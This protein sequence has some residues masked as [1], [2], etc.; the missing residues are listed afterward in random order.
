MGGKVSVNMA[1]LVS[2]ATQAVRQTTDRTHAHGSSPVSETR[3]YALTSGG[4]Y[5]NISIPD[6]VG[7]GLLPADRVGDMAPRYVPISVYFKDEGRTML[8]VPWTP[9]AGQDPA[10]TTFKLHRID[11]KKNKKLSRYSVTFS[12]SAL[13]PNF[14]PGTML[15]SEI[16]YGGR[17][18][19]GLALFGLTHRP[20]LDS[21][22][23][24]RRKAA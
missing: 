21:Y 8:I 19:P 13:P 17:Q 7:S 16:G 2:M 14:K 15:V 10:A 20:R 22:K 5:I 18:S 11:T 12:A 1:A 3:I 23:N 9:S 24:I 6:M 4:A